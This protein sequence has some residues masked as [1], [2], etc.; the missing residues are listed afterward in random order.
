MTYDSG[1]E[2]NG[3]D[4]DHKGGVPVA[5]SCNAE[6]KTKLRDILNRLRIG[7]S[8]KLHYYPKTV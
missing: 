8:Q 7:I 5:Q 6:R 4:T 2:A 3:Q 1:I